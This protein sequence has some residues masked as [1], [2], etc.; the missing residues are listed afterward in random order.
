MNRRT[1]VCKAI[2]TSRGQAMA[3]YAP[4]LATIAVVASGLV[5]DAGTIVNPLVNHVS[6]LF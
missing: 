5:Q 2:V 1:G 4:I 3:E 6:E